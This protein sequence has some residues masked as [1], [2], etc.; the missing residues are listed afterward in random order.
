V[1]C[2]KTYHVV[3]LQIPCYMCSKRERLWNHGTSDLAKMLTFY[4]LAK[5]LF[6]LPFSY[7][8]ER[9]PHL[10]CCN[11]AAHSEKRMS[12]Y[13][14]NGFEYRCTVGQIYKALYCN[15]YKSNRPVSPIVSSPNASISS[16][17]Q[18]IDSTSK[19]SWASQRVLLDKVSQQ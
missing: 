17:F 6:L 3:H 16:A 7:C 1:I 13:I 4:D 2:F 9:N 11:F 8:D 5:L 14:H 18:S 15:N 10:F 19:K 12:N